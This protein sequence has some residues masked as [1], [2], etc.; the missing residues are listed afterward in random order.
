MDPV[1]DL[2]FVGN[3]KKQGVFRSAQIHGGG[4][5]DF[6]D[7]LVFLGTALGWILVWQNYG[8]NLMTGV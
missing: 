2:V 6:F 4:A 8:F 3:R 5:H 1:G 7:G